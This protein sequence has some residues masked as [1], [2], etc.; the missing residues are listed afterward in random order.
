MCGIMNYDNLDEFG[1]QILNASQIAK[2]NVMSFVYQT[3][4]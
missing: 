2:N 3:N 1:K 4:C